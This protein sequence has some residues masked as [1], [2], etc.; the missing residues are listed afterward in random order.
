MECVKSPKREESLEEEGGRIIRELQ[1]SPD[2]E[3]TLEEDLLETN[4]CIT[5][6]EITTLQL[7]MEQQKHVLHA[8]IAAQVE[9]HFQS[10]P[11]FTKEQRDSREEA[12]RAFAKR[13]VD[14]LKEHTR[15]LIRAAYVIQKLREA[16]I[17]VFCR[18][19]DHPRT[20]STRERAG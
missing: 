3:Q 17:R 19:H 2:P 18:N 4:A 16:D 1:N 14:E 12:A 9:R 5:Q 13:H 11:S 20:L 6:R 10:H 7:A 15:E 8:R